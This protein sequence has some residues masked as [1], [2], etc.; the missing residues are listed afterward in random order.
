M[1]FDGLMYL[2]LFN[3]PH[4]RAFSDVDVP[5]TVES[6]LVKSYQVKVG[7]NGPI[8]VRT[9]LAVFSHQDSYGPPYT[10]LLHLDLV[11]Q[12]MEALNHVSFMKH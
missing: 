8:C 10:S 6:Y 12:V 11:H 3:G 9:L 2:L 7:L 4:N 1:S 5:L